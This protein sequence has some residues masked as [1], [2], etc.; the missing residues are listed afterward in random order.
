MD[1]LVFRATN[2]IDLGFLGNPY[3]WTNRRGGL[4]NIHEHLDRV[5]AS[6]KWKMRFPNAEVVHHV[7]STSNHNPIE[8]N[9]FYN[10]SPGPKPFRFFEAW[11]GD[12]RCSEVIKE[13]WN[14]VNGTP[15]GVKFCSRIKRIEIAL[16]R[17]N[18]EIFGFCQ[19]SIKD[20]EN[21]LNAIRASPLL[22]ISIQEEIQIQL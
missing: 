18:K 7:A 9:L 5:I 3:T 17:W 11:S 19:E 15:P 20:L 22:N 13:A 14:R 10:P 12:P 2:A 8:L 21:K 1:C 6:S 16:K 4:A